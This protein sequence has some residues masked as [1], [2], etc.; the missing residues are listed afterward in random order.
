[1]IKLDIIGDIHGCLD[2][3]IQLL[4]K[5]G[6][7]R[8][9]QGL[10]CHPNRI[11]ISVGDLIDR[12]PRSIDV[13][14][15]FVNH[16][17]SGRAKFVI[18]NHDDKFLR[19]ILGNP[20]EIREDLAAT[21]GQYEKLNADDKLKI[22]NML[23]SAPYKLELDEGRLLIVH[24]APPEG[25]CDKQD[26]NICLYGR[27][28]GGK[29]SRGFA[30]RFDWAPEYDLKENV[31]FVV[32]GHTYFQE[33]YMM[34]NSCGIDTACFGGEKLTALRWPDKEI[35]QVASAFDYKYV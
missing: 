27:P 2:E 20:V 29:D 13:A 21:I 11:F 33:P 23:K 34:K 31:P 26:K 1:M 14:L 19:Y 35:V 18:G 17:E 7:G 30:E 6:Y 5:L 24:A 22:F 9:K 12:G 15:F 32:Y 4:E 3:L 28:T 10:Y 16:I 8:N 25:Q